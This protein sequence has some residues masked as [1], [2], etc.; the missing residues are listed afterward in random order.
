MKLV[1]LEAE[2]T[3]EPVDRQELSISGG[4]QHRNSRRWERGSVSAMTHAFGVCHTLQ[5]EGRD[6]LSLASWVPL[7][8]VLAE[9]KGTGGK[10]AKM[11]HSQHDLGGRKKCCSLLIVSYVAVFRKM[12]D[13]GE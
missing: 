10:G 12:F 7:T 2:S 9:R 13:V 5:R 8:S 1:R 11:S 6:T 4:G 3:V